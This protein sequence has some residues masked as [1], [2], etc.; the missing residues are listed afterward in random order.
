MTI[1]ERE[2]C[3]TATTRLAD[4][5]S[6]GLS[7]EWIFRAADDS[8]GTT[9]D[10]LRGEGIENQIIYRSFTHAVEPIV[11][12]VYNGLSYINPSMT[13]ERIY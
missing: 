5:T 7:R 6:D 11:L 4:V 12:K 13:T 3:D 9:F 10:T 1:S 8:T 2:L